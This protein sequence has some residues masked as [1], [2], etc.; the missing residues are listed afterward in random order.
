MADLWF[1][2]FLSIL[3]GT[4]YVWVGLPLIQHRKRRDMGT[5]P[6]FGKILRVDGSMVLLVFRQSPDDPTVYDALNAAD[7]SAAVLHV[8]DKLSADV[9]GPGQ[10]IMIRME[11][12]DL[13]D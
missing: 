5:R 8:G 11:G 13:G 12:F 9:I 7:E 1:V 10:S 6:R 2:A 3:V 4:A